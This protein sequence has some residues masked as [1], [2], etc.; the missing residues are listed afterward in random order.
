MVEHSLWNAH[1]P[2]LAELPGADSL[3]DIPAPFELTALKSSDRNTLIVR[4]VNWSDQRQLARLG[5][6]P[7][8]GLRRARALT[9]ANAGS[10]HRPQGRPGDSP[11]CAGILTVELA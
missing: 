2:G 11:P 6:S 5:L 1:W 3:L 7:L 8:L 10:I 9:S 4:L